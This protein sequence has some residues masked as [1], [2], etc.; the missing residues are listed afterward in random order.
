MLLLHP[1]P[2]PS[3]CSTPSSSCTC[4]PLCRPFSCFLP[5]YL[6]TALHHLSVTA[7]LM[8]ACWTVTNTDRGGS[9]GKQNEKGFV[10]MRGVKAQILLNAQM[11]FYGSGYVSGC[12]QDGK[13]AREAFKSDDWVEKLCKKLI[14]LN[15]IKCLYLLQGCI[16]DPRVLLLVHKAPNSSQIIGCNISDIN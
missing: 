13:T 2:S 9:R 8:P 14:H 11:L 15:E 4:L 12:R 7:V 1:V 10:A 5:P 3:L 6:P 16:F